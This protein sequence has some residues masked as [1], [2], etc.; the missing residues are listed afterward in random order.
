MDKD[1]VKNNFRK[2]LL[3]LHDETLAGTNGKYVTVLKRTMNSLEWFENVKKY[4]KDY[5]DGFY[6][7]YVNGKRFDLSIEAL[8]LSNVDYMN[9]FT[10]DEIDACRERLKQV[11]YSG[12][13]K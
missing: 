1:I 9:L 10:E 8:I 7:L 2:R 12:Y 5:D 13:I 4:I 11:E 3:L 6:K